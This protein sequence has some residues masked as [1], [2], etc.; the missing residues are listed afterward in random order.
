MPALVVVQRP[1][2]AGLEDVVAGMWFVRGPAPT[3]FERILPSPDVAL[4][5]PL[6]AQ[7]YR[8][9]EAAGWRALGGTFV[10]GLRQEATIS[11]NGAELGNV[12]ATVRADALRAIGFDP[13]V[14]AGGVREVSGFGALE[15]LAPAVAAEDALDTLTQTLRA[16]LDDRWRPDPVV[17]ASIVRF[18]ED[19]QPRV[20]EVARTEGVSPPALVARFRRAT[21]VTPKAYADLMRLHGLLERLTAAALSSSAHADDDGRVVWS[22]L[23]VESGYYDQSHLT[24]AFHRFVG[25]TPAA[26]FDGVRGRGPDAVRF[27]PEEEAPAG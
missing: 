18:A 9:H 27:V 16:R 7:P 8:V 25:L 22:E 19:P 26:Y 1:A 4:V 13:G 2:P 14:L 5:V 11:S 21:G 24:R 10:A 6:A 12:G 3:P 15:A 17:R 20:S 23:A